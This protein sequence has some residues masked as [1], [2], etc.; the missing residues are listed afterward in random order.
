M[1][2]NARQAQLLN[3]AQ[4]LHRIGGIRVHGAEGDKP[5]SQLAVQNG[6]MV[7]DGVHLLRAGRN[8]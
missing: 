4:F 2:L 3:P 6:R 8:V 7:V 1:Q 5:S